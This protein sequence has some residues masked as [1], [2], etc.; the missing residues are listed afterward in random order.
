MTY[1]YLGTQHKG[2]D[3]Y[4]YHKAKD[5]VQVYQTK[6]GGP[7]TWMCSLAAWERTL[8]VVCNSMSVNNAQEASLRRKYEQSPS[9]FETFEE[10]RD[11]VRP[12]FASKGTVM[13]LWCGMWLG[14]EPDGH[15]HS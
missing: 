2:L 8:H 6:N 4:T 9:G 11:S 15:T 1:I 13:V 5:G 10:F 7:R 3:R 12:E 14:I